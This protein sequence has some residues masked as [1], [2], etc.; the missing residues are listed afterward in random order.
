MAKWMVVVKLPDGA[1]EKLLF[2]RFVLDYYE[3]KREASAVAK[4]HNRLCPRHTA[5]VERIKH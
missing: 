1:R 3:T 4:E 5:T 2:Q